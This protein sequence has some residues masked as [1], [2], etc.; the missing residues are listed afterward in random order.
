MTHTDTKKNIK[1]NPNCS[2]THIS[3][4]FLIRFGFKNFK[5]EIESIM[6]IRMHTKQRGIIKITSD[7]GIAFSCSQIKFILDCYLCSKAREPLI[8][9]YLIYQLKY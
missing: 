4:Q 7:F 2:I 8:R 3:I 1:L 5:M 6:I 9:V